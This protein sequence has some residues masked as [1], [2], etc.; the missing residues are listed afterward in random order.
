MRKIIIIL[1][2]CALIFVI[3]I[4]INSI[5]IPSPSKLNKYTIPN[6]EFL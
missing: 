5:K 2:I 4:A 6:E 3:F 1:A